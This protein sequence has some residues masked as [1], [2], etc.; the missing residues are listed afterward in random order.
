MP[1]IEQETALAA[2]AASSI[3][4]E[5]IP[6][7]ARAFAEGGE[8]SLPAALDDAARMLVAARTPLFVL[9]CDSAAT[10]TALNLAELCNGIVDVAESDALSQELRA[11]Q[12]RGGFLTTRREAYARADVV[13]VVRKAAQQPPFTEQLRSVPAPLEAEVGRTL[14]DITDLPGPWP[15]ADLKSRLAMLGALVRPNPAP[16]FQASEDHTLQAF[17]N[18]LVAA[19]FG[20]VLWSPGDL[21]SL[22]IA[23]L[24]SLL[25]SL[26][27]VT[28][29]TS[30]PLRAPGNAWGVGQVALARWGVPP[31][32]RWLGAY[33]EY[34]PWRYAMRRLI[35]PGEADAVVFVSS[36]P[37]QGS[38]PELPH[39]RTVWLGPGAGPAGA[40]IAMEAGASGVDYEGEWYDETLDAFCAR[41]ASAPSDAPSTAALLDQLTTR[42]K[43]A[44]R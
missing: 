8:T 30:L 43:E 7:Q 26:N 32:A 11:W 4:S 37:G 14:L 15:A 39:E 28:R 2:M 13:L 36:F 5:H 3:P 22:E 17:A 21:D 16:A 34:D 9:A 19:E 20:V 33:A 12:E 1:I 29:F 10:N 23:S 44:M 24:M 18:Q 27:E 6:V 25:N 40:R 35:R 31:R 41:A 38:A 42:V